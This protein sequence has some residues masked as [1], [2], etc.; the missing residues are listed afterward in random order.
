MEGAGAGSVEVTRSVP[1]LIVNPCSGSYS[2]SRVS[3]IIKELKQ[4][5]PAPH[6]IYARSP[7]EIAAQFRMMPLQTRDRLIIVAAG[8]GTFNAIINCIE[9]GSATLAVL[10]MGTSNVLAAELGIRSLEEGIRRIARFDVHPLPVGLMEID[11]GQFRFVLMAGIGLDGAIARDIRPNEKRLLRQGAFAL[12]A[13]RNA[14]SWDSGMID[15]ETEERC[16]SCHT[17]VICN[18]CRYGGDFALATGNS[19]LSP[20]F[21]IACV[22]SSRRSDYLRIAGGLFIGGVLGPKLEYIN[23]TEVQIQGRK[24]VQIDGDFIGYSPARITVAANFAGILT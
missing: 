1:L 23:S 13:L 24:P 5:S 22:T 18:A 4:V 12:S 7:A 14:W 20:R 2:G 8:D 17:A 10:P 15:V 6:V 19:L 21:T 9:P 3:Y 11:T 16:I